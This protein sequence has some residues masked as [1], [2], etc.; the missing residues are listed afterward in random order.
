[1]TVDAD[2]LFLAVAL[3]DSTRHA[4]AAHLETS[5]QGHEEAVPGKKVPP[6]NWHITLRF[7]G[8]SSAV[9][10]DRVMADLDQH[11]M[12]EPF[13]IRFTDLG[14]FPR[15]SKAS[16]LWLGVAGAV[17]SLVALAAAS[18]TAAQGAHF[19]PEGRPFHPH[20]T[21]ARIRPPADVRPLADLVSPARVGLDV[22]AV[23]LYRSVLGKG[24][25]R[26]EV[27]DT[28]DL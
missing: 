24:P 23:T 26:Y 25:A 5:L 18:E 21:L 11:V 9:Q 28:I 2:R 6:E 1:V 13:R 8:R 14:G 15:E 3:D 20:L 4:I 17:D 12:V 19:E 16:V 10:R 22:N 7:L 27:L